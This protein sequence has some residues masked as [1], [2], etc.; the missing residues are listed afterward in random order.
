MTK[1][2]T[3]NRKAA[4]KR[5][6]SRALVRAAGVSLALVLGAC[7]NVQPAMGPGAFGA[8]GSIRPAADQGHPGAQNLLGV[9]YFKGDEVPRNFDAAVRWWT[10]AAAQGDANAQYNLGFL[11]ADEQRRTADIVLA[12]M[13]LTIAALHGDE[14]AAEY[15]THVA[16]KMTARERA[17]ADTLAKIWLDQTDL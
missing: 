13:W 16:Q 11:Y 7:S 5:A 17:E 9:M 6:T 8:L 1:S 14:A 10:L 4:P 12:H 15:R 3:A 2:T